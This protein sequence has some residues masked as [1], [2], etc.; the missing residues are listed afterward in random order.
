MTTDPTNPIP[1][2]AALESL[3]AP[4]MLEALSALE[5]GA[6]VRLARLAWD[7]GCSLPDEDTFLAA[8]ARTTPEEFAAA[9]PRLL[10]AFGDPN[11]PPG[12]A[13]GG[14]R[15]GRL[16]LPAARKVFDAL[17]QARARTTAAKR[18]AGKAGAASR[19]GSTTPDHQPDRMAP[20][21]SRMAAAKQVPSGAMPRARSGVSLPPALSL[22]RSP[23]SA[24]QG[25]PEGR[26]EVLALMGEGARAIEA[27]RV[28][29]WRRRHCA[30][31]LETAIAEWRAEGETTFP[32]TR[33]Q[34]LASARHATPARIDTLIEYARGCVAAAKAAREA[35]ARGEKPK[36]RTEC[37]PVGILLHGLGESARSHGRPQD[38]TLQAATRWE[39]QEA[40]MR[41]LLAATTAI[42]SHRARGDAAPGLSTPPAPSGATG[43]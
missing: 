15:G 40:E 34:E 19:W 36:D 4:G 33:I 27:Q 2:P 18:E 28:Q 24:N 30:R 29:D 13:D 32:L 26:A 35:K 9:R 7:Q 31:M 5:L 39:K 38:P 8:V 37:S 22:Q 20:D 1:F 25:A 3:A 41:R 16:L 42:Q 12:P 17:V 21:S 6:F 23:E 43:A 14:G 10:L 11:P